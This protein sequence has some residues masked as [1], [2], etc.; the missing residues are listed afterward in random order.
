MV[1]FSGSSAG[2]EN[3]PYGMQVVLVGSSSFSKVNRLYG[4]QVVQFSGSSAGKENIPYGEQVVLV[5]G[6]SASKDN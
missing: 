2:K 6:S 3:I 1:Q 5:G 4:E